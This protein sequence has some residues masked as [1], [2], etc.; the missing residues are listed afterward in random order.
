MGKPRPLGAMESWVMSEGS[1][2]DG[3]RYSLTLHEDV[4]RDGEITLSRTLHA[5]E[6]TNGSPD[7]G[8]FLN[9]LPQ[10]ASV[11]L[12]H[13]LNPNTTTRIDLPENQRPSLIGVQIQFGPL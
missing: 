12:K 4:V 1:R 2:P 9:I 5:I 11:W 6:Y 13:T 10:G 7:K 8:C 3:T